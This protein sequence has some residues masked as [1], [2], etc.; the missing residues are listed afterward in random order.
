MNFRVMRIFSWLF[1][2]QTFALVAIA[3]CAAFTGESCAAFT[4]V[5][6]RA[7]HD[8]L[9]DQASAL[10][11]CAEAAECNPSQMRALARASYCTLAATLERHGESG[12]DAGVAC[13]RK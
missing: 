4:Q 9:S 10:S 2:G 7:V 11:L 13:E 1:A 12:V 3:S 6:S 5:D 8:A